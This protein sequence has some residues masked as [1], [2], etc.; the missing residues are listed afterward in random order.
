[1]LR[2]QPTFTAIAIVILALGI[3]ANT[4]IF[5]IVDPVLLRRLPNSQPVFL[6]S[7]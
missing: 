4:T 3:G 7:D 5:S 6:S 1:M 2:R